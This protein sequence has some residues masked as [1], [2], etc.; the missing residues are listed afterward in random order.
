[1]FNK[2]LNSKITVIIFILV[3]LTGIIIHD[4]NQW[5]NPHH[6]ALIFIVN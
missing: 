2:V 1:M 3:V 6:K 4:Y 5:N